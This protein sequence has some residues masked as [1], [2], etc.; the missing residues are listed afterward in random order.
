MYIKH[1]ARAWHTQALYFRSLGSSQK[2]HNY[3]PPAF[4][5]WQSSQHHPSLLID[6]SL[7]NRAGTPSDQANS[8]SSTLRNPPWKCSCL[9]VL[10]LDCLLPGPQTALPGSIDPHGLQTAEIWGQKVEIFVNQKEKKKKMRSC[11]IAQRTISSHLWWNTMGD[12][13]RKRIYIYIY[14]YIYMIGSLCCMTEID[15]TL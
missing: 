8:H 4:S 1:F 13:D 15:R 12:N 2:P 6:H 5:P 9:L 14:I 7:V 10:D 11:C 3:H